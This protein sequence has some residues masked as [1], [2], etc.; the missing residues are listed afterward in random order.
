MNI[1]SIYDKGLIVFKDK[2]FGLESFIK[3][4]NIIKDICNPDSLILVIDDKSIKS[5]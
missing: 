5:T 1:N 4:T 2:E 3:G